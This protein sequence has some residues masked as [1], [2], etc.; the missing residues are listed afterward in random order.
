MFFITTVTFILVHEPVVAQDSRSFLLIL[1]EEIHWFLDIIQTN[2]RS[3]VNCFANIKT[4]GKASVIGFKKC[5]HILALPLIYFIDLNTV[6]NYFKW[7]QHKSN[8]IKEIFS[9]CFHLDILIEFLFVFAWNN[10]PSFSGTYMIVIN[11]I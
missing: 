3:E 5:T 9:A 11:R 7:V 8:T 10:I 1:Q 4:M 2:W 6:S